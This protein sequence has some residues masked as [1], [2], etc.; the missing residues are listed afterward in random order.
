MQNLLG[1]IIPC[2]LGLLLL[3]VWASPVAADSLCA[4]ITKIVAKSGDFVS[5]K[6]EAVEGERF[7]AKTQINGFLQCTVTPFK[8]KFS[9][10]CETAPGVSETSALKRWTALKGQLENCLKGNWLQRN[11]GKHNAFFANLKTGEA[12]SLSMREVAGFRRVSNQLKTFPTYYN[13]LSVF[14]RKKMKKEKAN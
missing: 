3:S 8:K 10:T 14:P 9:Y 6:G 7:K 11:A 4:E 5:L 2:I 12:M 1:K 13:R